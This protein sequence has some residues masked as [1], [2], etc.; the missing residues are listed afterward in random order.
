MNLVEV[1]YVTGTKLVDGLTMDGGRNASIEGLEIV[2]DGILS[3]PCGFGHDQMSARQELAAALSWTTV[4]KI[5]HL[6]YI[7]PASH[8]VL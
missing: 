7:Q 1:A 2:A 5:T 6:G 3:G 4:T 8:T